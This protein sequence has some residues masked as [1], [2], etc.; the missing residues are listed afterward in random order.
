MS[1]KKNSPK[2]EK[3]KEKSKNNNIIFTKNNAISVDLD[4]YFE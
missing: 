2:K 1:E 4:E 3:E